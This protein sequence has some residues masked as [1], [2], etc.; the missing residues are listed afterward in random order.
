M[1]IQLSRMQQRLLLFLHN[2]TSYIFFIYLFRMCA[3][4]L[5][6]LSDN[7]LQR[8]LVAVVFF[9]PAI[10]LNLKRVYSLIIIKIF[11]SYI[12]SKF[13]FIISYKHLSQNH[14]FQVTFITISYKLLRIPS[15]LQKNI[16]WL[17]YILRK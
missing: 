2:I 3:V 9:N 17:V 6:R 16:V 1:T 14:S 11:F 13:F 15:V 12:N 7:L 4:T 5:V 10:F 8:F